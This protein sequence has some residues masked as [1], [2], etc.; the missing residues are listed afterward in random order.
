MTPH[1]A[2]ASREIGGCQFLL[3]EKALGG[4]VIAA[5]AAETVRTGRRGVYHVARKNEGRRRPKAAPYG[6]AFPQSAFRIPHFF[7]ILS[8]LSRFS[9]AK[10]FHVKH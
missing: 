7:V 3:Q 8:N 4:R 1:P 9:A 5:P 2:S 10:K 6:G